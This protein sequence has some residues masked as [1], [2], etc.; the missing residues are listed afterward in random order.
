MREHQ[1]FWPGTFYVC[2]FNPCICFDCHNENMINIIQWCSPES[3]STV[4]VW[5]QRACK[6]APRPS[7]CPGRRAVCPTW[8]VPTPCWSRGSQGPWN[9]NRP[10]NCIVSTRTPLPRTGPSLPTAAPCSGTPLWRKNIVNI[11]IY[12][13]IYIYYSMT[14]NSYRWEGTRVWYLEGQERRIL[15]LLDGGGRMIWSYSRFSSFARTV[16][17]KI[18][19]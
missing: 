17:L 7:T 18:Y 11:G 14:C 16:N 12:K 8:P 10:T 19:L 2:H 9:A 6:P 1:T 4:A 3:C 13:Y 15:F 5:R